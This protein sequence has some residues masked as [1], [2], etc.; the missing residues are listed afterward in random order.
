MG[1]P[2]IQVAASADELAEMAA[3]L[4]TGLIAETIESAGTATLALSGGSTPLPTYRLMAQKLRPLSDHIHVFQVDE[5]YVPVD[6]PANNYGSIR[7]T[8]LEPLAISPSQVHRIPTE[9]RPPEKAARAY[10]E[11]IRK[12]FGLTEGQ[13]PRF[14]AIVLGLGADGHTASLFPGSDA[15][16]EDRK[17]ALAVYVP[18]VAMWRIT[19]TLP[20]INAARAIVFLVSGSQKAAAVQRVLSGH[21]QLPASLVKPKA[22]RLL[23]LLDAAAAPKG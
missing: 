22:G 18:Q 10:E 12:H 19:L 20:A 2:E 17:L 8:L 5:R 14:D 9:L 15:L 23:W 3:Q 7:A 21:L 11:D 16:R 6:D 1:G 13:F 4:L